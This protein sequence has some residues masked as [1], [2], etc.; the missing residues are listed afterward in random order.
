MIYGVC[1]RLYIRM[2][3]ISGSTAEIAEPIVPVIETAIATSGYACPELIS[4]HS[5]SHIRLMHCTDPLS[6]PAP[7]KYESSIRVTSTTV[8]K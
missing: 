7:L 2:Y 5:A 8:Q 3:Q 1:Y 6:P 4:I